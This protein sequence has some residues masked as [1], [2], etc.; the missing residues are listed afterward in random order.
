MVRSNQD[1][2][3]SLPVCICICIS[4]ACKKALPLLTCLWPLFRSQQP[5]KAWTAG[6]QLSQST[7][8]GKPLPFSSPVILQSSHLPLL[9]CASSPVGNFLLVYQ[10]ETLRFLCHCYLNENR[11]PTVASAGKANQAVVSPFATPP[12]HPTNTS[13]QNLLSRGECLGGQAGRKATLSI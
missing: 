12:P 1:C 2:I 3:S 9:L 6:S 4:K 7:R 8:L 10:K 13:A 11:N 5:S